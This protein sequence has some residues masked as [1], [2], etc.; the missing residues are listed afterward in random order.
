MTDVVSDL[1]E[2]LPREISRLIDA[3]WIAAAYVVLARGESPREVRDAASQ[4]LL[5]A[6]LPNQV[7]RHDQFLGAI[8]SQLSQIAGFASGSKRWTDLDDEVLISQGL[9]S[10][11]AG[12]WIVDEIMPLAGLSDRF[13]RPGA[14]FLDVGT[15]TGQLAAQIAGRCPGTTVVGIDVAE[16]PLGIAHALLKRSGQEQ[17]VELRQANVAEL[18]EPGA[19]DLAWLP[20]GFI[21]ADLL[22]KALDNVKRALRPGGWV[23]ATVEVAEAGLPLEQAISRLATAFHG[24]TAVTCA[25]GVRTLRQAG[26]TGVMELPTNIVTGPLVGGRKA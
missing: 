2:A 24:G 15:G 25:D 19:F 7:T 8:C 14:A 12:D 5:R 17:A 21:A 9:A 20:I 13:A 26:F 3:G 18:D 1:G 23:I 22:P 11:L 6:G 4:V 10:R 16:R